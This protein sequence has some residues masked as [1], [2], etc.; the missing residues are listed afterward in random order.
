M[1]P[2]GRWLLFYRNNRILQVIHFAKTSAK[3]SI[4]RIVHRISFSTLS[5]DVLVRYEAS[6]RLSFAKSLRK[7]SDAIRSKL[8]PVSRSGIIRT[9]MPSNPF[10]NCSPNSLNHIWVPVH[11]VF[12]SNSVISA[13]SRTMTIAQPFEVLS[14]YLPNDDRTCNC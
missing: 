14:V 1:V 12:V 8:P 13:Y 4:V 6:R 2:S 3:Q 10:S 11:F 9:Q 7:P 5:R